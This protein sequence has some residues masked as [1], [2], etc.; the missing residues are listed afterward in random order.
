[1]AKTKEKPLIGRPPKFSNPEELQV[2]IDDY[3]KSG[4]AKRDI[5]V[6]TGANKKVVQIPLPTITGLILS[7]GFA[8]RYSFYEYEK[9]QDFTYTIK[10]AR[11]RIEKEYEEMLQ[12]GLGAGAIFALKNFGWIDK[13]EHSFDDETKALLGSA[14]QRLS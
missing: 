1:M 6:G 4:V 8:D 9:K 2:K 12:S 14:L 11:A 3:F 10:R 13:Q 5:I 7:C